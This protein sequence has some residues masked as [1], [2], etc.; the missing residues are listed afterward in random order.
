MATKNQIAKKIWITDTMQIPRAIFSKQNCLRNAFEDRVG[1]STRNSESRMN[2][3]F[4]RAPD[5]GD[6]VLI[7]NVKM[8][9]G[10]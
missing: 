6:T 4:L 2:A 9:I 7:L 3:A 8:L 1:M 10:E 5:S